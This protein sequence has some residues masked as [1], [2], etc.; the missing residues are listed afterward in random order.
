LH[1]FKWRLRED[2]SCF[3][4]KRRRR[5]RLL[6]LIHRVWKD[7]KKSL[8]RPFTLGYKNFC[9]FQQVTTLH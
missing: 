5:R 3:V 2:F 6:L 7:S 1:I 4:K 9:L 8:V